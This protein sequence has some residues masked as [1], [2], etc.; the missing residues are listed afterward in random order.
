MVKHK[1]DICS[2]CGKDISESSPL[3]HKIRQVIDIEI[4]PIAIQHQAEVKR[5]SYCGMQTSAAFPK[6]VSHYIQY[7]PYFSALMVCLSQANHIPYDRLSKLSSDIFKI[8]V[9]CGT[10]VNI[11]KRCAFSLKDSMEYI[12]GQLKKSKVIHLDET[13]IRANKK[14]N[15]LHNT[16][17]SKYTYVKTHLKRGS[18]ATDE[19][20]ILPE[21]KGIAVHDFWK[22]YY[23]YTECAHAIC[24]AHILR[25]LNAVI[26]N[27]GQA[28]ATAMKSLLTEIN[29]EVN[30]KQGYL[31]GPEAKKYEALYDDILSMADKENPSKFESLYSAMTGN[32][33]FVFDTS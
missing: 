32:P 5:C 13:S 14:T 27:K 2:H 12:K 11:V 28:W 25:E 19:I 26:E 6:E 22:S 18:A 30:K 10:L 7:G 21:F 29:R 31:L 1:I 3:K 20:G 16:S 4:K 24:N 15:W 23:N 9:S 33:L 8:P 17:N